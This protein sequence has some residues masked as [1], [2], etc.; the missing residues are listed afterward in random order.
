[1]SKKLIL[2]SLVALFVFIS[3]PN[4]SHAQIVTFNLPGTDGPFDFGDDVG[5]FIDPVTG[6]VA[7]FA[8]FVDGSSGDFNAT[9]DNFG[10]NAEE[11]GCLL[12]TSPSPRDQRGSR[13]PS[14]A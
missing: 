14:S 1:M 3:S 4:T 5:Q 8:A 2:S 6:L 7:D 9:A 10:I 12:Y 11:T 13:M